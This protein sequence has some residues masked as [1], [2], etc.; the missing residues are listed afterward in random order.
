[1]GNAL[2]NCIAAVNS[3]FGM[4]DTS[5]MGMGR[6]AGNLDLGNLLKHFDKYDEKKNIDKF[7]SKEMSNLKKKY[8]WGKNSLYNFSAKNNI[9]PTFVQRLLSEEKFNKSHTLKILN[10]LKKSSATQ[11]D[12]NIFDNLFLDINKR[13]ENLENFGSKKIILLCDNYENKKIN[14]K[15]KKS[16]K[17]LIGSLN[18]IK[19]VNK[20]YLDLI[21]QCNAYRVFTELEKILAI[22]KIK[23]V[24]PNYILLNKFISKLKNKIIKYNIVKSE[25]IEISKL[26]CGFKKNLVL[27]Y[28][29]SFCISNKFDEIVIYGLTKNQSNMNVLNEINKYLIDTNLKTS[30]KLNQSSST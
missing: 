5:V 8:K 1:M 17:W 16:E 4:I 3:G 10:F 27:L 23:L 20:N 13:R 21:F 30:I 2:K 29:L 11:Y 7:S 25:K 15:Q 14:L 19:F 26:Q 18:Y 28:A 12:M 22:K 6:G 9:H 24:M